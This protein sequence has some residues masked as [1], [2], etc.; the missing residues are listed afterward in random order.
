[1]IHVLVVD[2]AELNRK[3]LADY[4]LYEGFTVTEAENGEQAV[5]LAK[6]LKPALILMDIQMPILDG[7]SAIKILKS[8]PATQHIKIIAITSFAMKG[9]R[10]KI[11]NSGCD[12]YIAKPID[13]HGLIEQIETIMEL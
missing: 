12:A 11:L 8:D 9:D 6:E 2:D 7:Y 13:M 4:M 5:H 1:M 3:L 10:E